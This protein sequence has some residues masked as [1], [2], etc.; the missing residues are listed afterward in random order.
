MEGSYMQ[1][2]FIG[3]AEQVLGFVL[4]DWIAHLAVLCDV[5]VDRNGRQ[6]GIYRTI[7]R[8]VGYFLKGEKTS[9]A[10]ILIVLEFLSQLAFMMCLK[11]G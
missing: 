11:L 10:K 3:R 9:T 5:N 6:T 1:E 7:I 2:G 8:E 4:S